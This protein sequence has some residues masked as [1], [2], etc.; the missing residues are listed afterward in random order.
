LKR[1]ST[2][3]ND[4]TRAAKPVRS[5]VQ[6]VDRALELL[7]VVVRAESAISLS[8]VSARV[9]LHKPTA[10]R[11]LQALSKHGLIKQDPDTRGYQAGLKL[12]ELSSDVLSRMELRRQALPELTELCRRANE[13]VHL[14]VLDD[15]DVIYIDK[16]E[17][18]Q[19]IRMFS[20]IGKRGPA[21]CTGVGKVLLAYLSP[22]D[23]RRIIATKGLKRYTSRTITSPTLLR[24]EL[25]AIRERGYA[26]DNAEHE[27]EIRC[28]ACPIRNHGGTVI[29]AV[30]LTAP[31]MRMSRERIDEIAPLVREYADRISSKMGY[32]QERRSLGR[33]GSRT[34]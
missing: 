12:F 4:S 14:A 31:V 33:A 16:E 26:I 17:T 32:V 23:L 3:R 28:A 9:R 22:D 7:E 8:D 6:S 29:A 5:A 30:S 2:I 27:E 15:G 1:S 21:H 34:R 11:L 20:A 10:H 25:D 13:T 18:Q 24:R 19:T